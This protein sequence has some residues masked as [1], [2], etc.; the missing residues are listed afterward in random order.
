VAAQPLL[1]WFRLRTRTSSR[2]G[3]VTAFDA[4]DPAVPDFSQAARFRLE[5]RDDVVLKSIPAL[6]HFGS[7]IDPTIALQVGE[8][9]L[10]RRSAY[11]EL[12]T[13]KLLECARCVFAAGEDFDDASANGFCEDFERVHQNTV[14]PLVGFASVFGQSVKAVRRRS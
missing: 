13:D 9:V 3:R 5:A 2:D 7:D 14:L 10:D 6:A 11:P 8:V 4:A 1:G 12:E